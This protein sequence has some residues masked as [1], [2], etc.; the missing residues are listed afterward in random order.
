MR[1]TV[2]MQSILII[3]KDKRERQDFVQK[4]CVEQNIDQIDRDINEHEGTIGI[5]QVRAMQKNLFLKPLKSSQKAV[6]IHDAQKLTIEAQNSLLKILEEPPN[7]TIIIL[8]AENKELLLPT[9]LS[10]C[11]I[12]ELS[13]FPKETDPTLADVGSSIGARLKLAQDLAKDKNEAILWLE[14]A[15]LALRQQLIGGKQHIKTIRSFQETYVIL[16]TTNANPRL[17]LEN[18]FLNL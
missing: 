3:S 4:I 5:A 13:T 9:I 6:I 16:K 12:I 1:Y 8:A 14:N 7:N 17:T 18:L 2:N 10:R 15:I 11:K